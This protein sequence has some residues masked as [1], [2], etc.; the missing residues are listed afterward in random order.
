MSSM[1]LSAN[2]IGNIT[3]SGIVSLTSMGKDKKSPGAPFYTYVQEVNMERKL[4]RSLETETNA[5]PLSWGK[6]LEGRVTS[7]MPFDYIPSGQQTI[8]H[9]TIDCWAGSP[10]GSSGGKKTH[11]TKCPIT[12]KSFCTFAEC[13]TIGDVREK[14]K[15]GDKYFWQIT[16]NA[17]LN[18][19]PEG[20][21]D[22]YMPYQHELQ[23]IRDLVDEVPAEDMSAYYW[24]SMAKDEDLPYLIEGKGYKN[25]YHIPFKIPQADIDFL[26]ERVLMAQ[27]LLIP[28]PKSE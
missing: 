7:L 8:M 27:E 25:I 21:L 5:R 13:E 19:H 18:G 15:D 23:E 6:L 3:N 2:R 4:G 26:T 20:Q 11:D 10:D 17:I 28:W 12:L 22:I 16:G 9:P 14:H 24:I 1:T